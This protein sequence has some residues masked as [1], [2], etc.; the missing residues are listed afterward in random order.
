MSEEYIQLGSPLRDAAADP[1]AAPAH[2]QLGTRL[3]DAAVDPRPE[4]YQAPVRGAD[5]KPV[6]VQA[7]S[8]RSGNPPYVNGAPYE[9]PAA[10]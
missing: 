3:R 5:G 10:G 4:D 7:L 1:N 6:S 9:A 8:P 2:I